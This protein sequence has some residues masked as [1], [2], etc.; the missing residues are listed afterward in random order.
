MLLTNSSTLRK[1]S[2]RFEILPVQSTKQASLRAGFFC[3]VAEA[4]LLSP[5][6]LRGCPQ[7]HGERITPQGFALPLRSACGLRVTSGA[8]TGPSHGPIQ[9]FW[10]I[11]AC[12]GPDNGPVRAIQAA[13][14]MSSSHT[15]SSSSRRAGRL[16][17]FARKS[18][19]VSR[20]ISFRPSFFICRR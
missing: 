3:L 4:S 13:S 15:R 17:Y 19:I 9:A 18:S 1:S 20:T 14:D 6:P 5:P 16:G 12:T 2:R 8:C 7:G 10:A 11:F